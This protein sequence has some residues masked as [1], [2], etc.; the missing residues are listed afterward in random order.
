V[1]TVSVVRV[2]I[3]RSSNMPDV[4]ESLNLLPFDQRENIRRGKTEVMDHRCVHREPYLRSL[5]RVGHGTHTVSW[6]AVCGPE[7]LNEAWAKE[8]P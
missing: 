6:C 3:A 4:D 7:W 1:G 2:H 8:N 5:T